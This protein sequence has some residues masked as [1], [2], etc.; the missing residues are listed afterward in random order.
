VLSQY[1]IEGEVLRTKG[2]IGLL[3]VDVSS[4]ISQEMKDAIS[5][6]PLEIKTKFLY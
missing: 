5:A 1:N 2:Q 4:E 6:L 3:I